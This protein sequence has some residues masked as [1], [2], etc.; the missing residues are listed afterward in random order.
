MSESVPLACP[1]CDAPLA[2]ATA[3][4]MH[5][6][7]CLRCGGVWLDNEGSTRIAKVCA[8]PQALALIRL[9]ARHALERAPKVADDS[10]AYRVPSE[11]RGEML[12]PVC[13]AR[14]VAV[15]TP[16]SIE[17]DVCS[18]HGTWFDV[19]EI[20]RLL[21]DAELSLHAPASSWTPDGVLGFVHSVLEADARSRAGGY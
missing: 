4:D 6:T 5:V 2:V 7:G 11:A 17:L 10:S 12:C 16:A 8:S 15:S 19:L 3:P 13:R 9:A 18:A 1:R 14:L 20:Q 21:S